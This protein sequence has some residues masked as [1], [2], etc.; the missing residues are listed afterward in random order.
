MKNRLL[1]IAAL[2]PIAAVNLPAAAQEPE[3]SGGK[4]WPGIPPRVDTGI[5]KA[6]T[7]GMHYEYRYGYDR[8]ARWRG[9]WALVR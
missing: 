2:A 5:T 3:S 6:V 1:A 4:T 7:S 8:H 9:Q